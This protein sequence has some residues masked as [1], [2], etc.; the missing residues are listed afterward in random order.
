MVWMVDRTVAW[1]AKHAFAS[2]EN[3]GV[4]SSSSAAMAKVRA[5]S[6]GDHLDHII[7]EFASGVYQVRRQAL[8]SVDLGF[9]GLLKKPIFQ[10]SDL[11]VY[12]AYR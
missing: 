12:R 7:A 9:A 11:K 4:R 2:C 5:A 8:Q 1:F 6:C 10:R 3:C